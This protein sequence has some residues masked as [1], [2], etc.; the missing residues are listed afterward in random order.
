MLFVSTPFTSIRE[1]TSVAAAGA[2]RKI[3][4]TE[5]EKIMKNIETS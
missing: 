2:A 3:I 5:K 1:K 4:P